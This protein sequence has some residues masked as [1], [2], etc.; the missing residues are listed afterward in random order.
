[1][2]GE[3]NCGKQDILC[4]RIINIRLT[5]KGFRYKRHFLL[6]CTGTGQEIREMRAWIKF[7]NILKETVKRTVVES[8]R[9]RE[10]FCGVVQ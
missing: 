4:Y 8:M 5:L 1:M 9:V 2:G 10:C 3:Y 6:Y 7:E